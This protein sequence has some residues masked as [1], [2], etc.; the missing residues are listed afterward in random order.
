MTQ[1][2]GVPPPLESSMKAVVPAGATIVSEWLR[3]SSWPV[4][5]V[6]G[7]RRYPVPMSSY[8]YA[9]VV[10]EQLLSPTELVVDLVDA[11][12]HHDF[13]HTD[14]CP[15]GT[16]VAGAREV[17]RGETLEASLEQLDK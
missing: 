8:A 16:Q 15:P 11:E 13:A 6:Q 4:F 10:C 17:T 14:C 7:S 9:C 1:V 3:T 2:W 12:G 5:L